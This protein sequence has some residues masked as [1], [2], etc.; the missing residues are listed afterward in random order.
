MLQC[1]VAPL[2]QDRHP[3][4]NTA[5]HTSI[6]KTAAVAAAAANVAIR[7]IAGVMLRFLRA[8]GAGAGGW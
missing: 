6:K 1:E 2:H 5:E 3:H 8:D 4:R 7:E